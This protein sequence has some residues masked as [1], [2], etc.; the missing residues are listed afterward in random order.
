M[1]KV[2]VKNYA[3]LILIIIV[4]FVLTLFLRNLYIKN[5]NVNKSNFNMI[6]VNDFDQYAIENSDLI[7]YIYNSNSNKDK[8]FQ[9]DFSNKLKEN[10]L[11]EYIVSIDCYKSENKLNRILNN[12][13]QID[14][15]TYSTPII[16]II[17]DNKKDSL[18]YVNTENYNIDV[19]MNYKVFK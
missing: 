14:V 1:R 19:L 9:V 15:D 16:L 5:S 6:E 3:I 2:P 13:Y 8:D 12:K 7:L 10:N 11:Y 18:I 4:V 17:K